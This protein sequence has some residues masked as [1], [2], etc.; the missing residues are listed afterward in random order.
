[1]ESTAAWRC[2]VLVLVLGLCVGDKHN[3]KRLVCWKAILQ[4]HSEAECLYAYEKYTHACASVLSGER[5]TC[6]RH[7]VTSLIQLNLTRGGSDLE[8]CD[9]A[10]DPLCA[11]AKRA[12]EQC[13]PRTRARLGCTHA[14]RRCEEEPACR[15]VMLDFLSHC[16]RVFSVSG[17]QQCSSECRAAMVRMRDVPAARALET[18]V[19]DGEEWGFCEYVQIS[20]KTFC[21]EGEEDGSGFSDWEDDDEYEDDDEDY[22]SRVDTTSARPS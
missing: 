6:P 10:L 9:C 3:Q 8:D 20:M 21:K 4:C 2:G 17:G 15:A 16:G 18:C 1:M 19:C 7:C 22:H 14:R 11:R 13:L 5:R 12:I